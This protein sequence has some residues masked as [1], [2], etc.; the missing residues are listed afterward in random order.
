[1]TTKFLSLRF[2][3]VSYKNHSSCNKIFM[4]LF[5]IDKYRQEIEILLEKFFC[6]ILYMSR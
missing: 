5:G 2:Y 6:H 1:M 3:I 4:Y